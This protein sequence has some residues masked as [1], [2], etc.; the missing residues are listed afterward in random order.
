VAQRSVATVLPELA[1]NALGFFRWGRVADKLLLTNDAGEWELLGES[2]FSDLLTGHVQAGHPRFLDFQRKGFLL[3]GLNLD[4]LAASV[5][6]RTRHMRRGVH[7]HV[8]TVTRRRSAASEAGV[9]EPGEADMSPATAEKIVDLALQS[10]T[11][12]VTFEIQGEAGEPLFNFEVLRHLVEYA[13]SRSK[14]AAGKTLTFKLLSNFTGMTEEIADWLIANDVLI[15]TTFDGPAGVHDRN[16]KWTRGSTYADVVRWIEHFHSAYEKLGRD[17]AL[18]HVDTLTLTTRQTM[19]AWRDV[20][21]EHVARGLRSICLVPLRSG[22]FDAETWAA[23]GYTA[24]Q[25]TDFY[26]RVLDYIV[27]LNRRGVEL[28]ERLASIVLT[29]ILT[30]EDPGA[31]DLQSPCGDGIAQ[32]AYDIEGRVFPCDEARVVHAAGD[33]MFE[34]GHVGNLTVGDV[35]RHP[36]IRTIAA[37]SLLD[38]QPMCAGCWNKPFC[39]FSPVHDFVEQGTL[40]GQRPRC[41]ECKEHMAVSRKLFELLADGD[42]KTTEILERW[43]S[44]RSRFLGDS[45]TLLDAP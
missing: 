18:W 6:Q 15:R 1:E 45:R 39:G 21:D 24:E 11:P 36:T 2:E 16:R 10:N 22:R 25:Y 9:V 37:A 44:T 8:V 35:A 14:R 13:V 23:E 42:G 20:V 33:S 43:V 7:L 30:A 31:V 3:E 12:S 28:S 41:F 38:A 29:K 32:L 19:E 34:I 40:F 4:A 5:A 17:R 27:E 26:R